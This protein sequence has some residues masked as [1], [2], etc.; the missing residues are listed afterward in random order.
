M[1]R[2]LLGIGVAIGVIVV[3]FVGDYSWLRVRAAR[4]QNPYDIVQIQ[5]VEQIPQKGNKAEY[6]PQ[7]PRMQSCVRSIFPHEN[8]QPCWYLRRHTQQQINF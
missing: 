6:V 3:L 8:Q 5:V 1:Q 7:D 2:V 4:N